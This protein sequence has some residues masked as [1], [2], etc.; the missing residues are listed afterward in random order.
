MWWFTVCV[1]KFLT[2][3]AITY[4]CLSYTYLT[5]PGSC[6]E[7]SINL[8]P[9]WTLEIAAPFCL[10]QRVYYTLCLY[11]LIREYNSDV[12]RAVLRLA[13]VKYKQSPFLG[14]IKL[15]EPF[16]RHGHRHFARLILMEMEKQTASSLETHNA[17]GLLVRYLHCWLGNL[18]C[19]K[20]TIPELSEFL[21]RQ[22]SI[23]LC[24]KWKNT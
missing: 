4:C 21:C 15:I 14:L 13:A 20:Y 8:N 5:Q 7:S 1:R 16:F 11:S 19:R 12:D 23:S 6:L 24:A 2:A 22:N 3:I 17:P 9:C 18:S 10:Y